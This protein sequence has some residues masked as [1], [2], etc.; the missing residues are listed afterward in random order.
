MNTAMIDYVSAAKADALGAT[1][2]GRVACGPGGG[3]FRVVVAARIA[4]YVVRRHAAGD[5]GLELV[6]FAVFGGAA[7]TAFEAALAEG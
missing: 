1:W 2:G 3:G 5:T 4:V 7:R 6:V